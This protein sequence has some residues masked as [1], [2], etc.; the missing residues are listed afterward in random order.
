MSEN[1]NNQMNGSSEPYEYNN[2][3]YQVYGAGQYV[4]SEPEKSNGMAIASLVLG[5]CSLACCCAGIPFSVVGLILG[6]IARKNDSS[7]NM[8][9]A[10]IILSAIGIVVFTMS[11]IF[12]F[13]LNYT[14]VPISDDFIPIH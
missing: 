3:Q 6:I 4:T 9:L 12:G 13:I 10:G 2:Q 7:D 8:A 11:F 1:Y 5:I 14:A